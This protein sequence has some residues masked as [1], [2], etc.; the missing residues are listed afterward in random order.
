W[1][2]IMGPTSRHGGTT[3]KLVGLGPAAHYED[4]KLSWVTPIAPTDAYFM[5]TSKLGRAYTHDL[6]VGTVKD[7]GVI[8]DIN[9]THTR[10]ALQLS[11]PLADG[12]ADNS[13]G[14]LLSEQSGIV[15]GTGF[16][17]V[18]D[19]QAGPGGLYVTSLSNGALYRIIATD[20]TTHMMS[21]APVPEPGAALLVIVIGPLLR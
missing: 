7:G 2:D 10:K 9:F 1:E 18:T 8:Y 11:G 5:E 6:F 4:P 20:A 13:A 17:T 19:L 14:A 12:V 21:V 15:F 3:G 16:G